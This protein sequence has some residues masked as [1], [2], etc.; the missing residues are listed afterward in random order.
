M[1]TVMPVGTWVKRT[2]DSVLFTCYELRSD[3]G[4]ELGRWI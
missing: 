4:A 2:A 1:E 3:Y